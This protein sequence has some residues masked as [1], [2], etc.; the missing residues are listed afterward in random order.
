M[1]KDD[2]ETVL[3]NLLELVRRDWTFGDD[4][5]R[6]GMLAFFDVLKDRRN[7]AERYRAHV[8]HSPLGAV[9]IGNIGIDLRSAPI[10]ATQR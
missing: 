9:W 1:V 2:Y 10:R 6:R 5:G 7:L 3:E 8:Q 4:A